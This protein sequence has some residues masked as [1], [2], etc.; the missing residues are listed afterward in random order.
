MKRKSSAYLI[1]WILC[2]SSG[3][4]PQEMTATLCHRSSTNISFNFR[5]T[6]SKVCLAFNSAKG[7]SLFVLSPRDMG[8]TLMACFFK[9]SWKGQQWPVSGFLAPPSL[10]ETRN[11]PR[12]LNRVLFL[13]SLARTW[14]TCEPIPYH[15]PHQLISHRWV[16]YIHLDQLLTKGI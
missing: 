8:L 5:C 6:S 9:E 15:T 1:S 3:Y 16:T 11:F 12:I 7:S 10:T 2:S 13:R 14:A 4:V